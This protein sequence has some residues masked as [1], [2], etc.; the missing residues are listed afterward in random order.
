MKHCSKCGV[1]KAHTDFYSLDR[2]CK[3]CRRKAAR[4]NY[5][6]NRERYREYERTR[7]NLPHRIAARNAYQQT[8]SWKARSA[9]AGSQKEQK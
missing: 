8:E 3:E 9:A 2:A 5:A 1:Q 7:N 6:N 4:A